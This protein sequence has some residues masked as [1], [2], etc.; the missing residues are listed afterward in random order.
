[1]SDYF[2]YG[3]VRYKGSSYEV[4]WN[5]ISHEVFVDW[6]GNELLRQIKQFP[7][8]SRHCSVMAEQQ[9]TATFAFALCAHCG[10]WWPGERIFET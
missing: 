6:A 4:T 3:H 9:V 7:R 1:M 10:K 5:S 2:R 8:S